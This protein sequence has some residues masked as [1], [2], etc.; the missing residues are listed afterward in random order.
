MTWTKFGEEFGDAARDL[1]DAAFR[2]HV[3]AIMWSNRRLTDLC[4]K[5]T[6]VKRFAETDDPDKAI[7]E[8]VDAGWWKENPSGWYIGCRFPEWQ[9]ES[10]VIEARREQTALRQRRHRLHAAGDHSLCTDK[11][12]ASPVTRDTTRD[13]MRDATRDPVRIG[14]ERIGTARDGKSS[15]ALAPSDNESTDDVDDEEMWQEYKAT[16]NEDQ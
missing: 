16:W 9:L 1:S 3:E 7:T 10:T 6:E 4:I 12:T 8:L 11:C 15:S 13:E 2:T 5:R 14:T